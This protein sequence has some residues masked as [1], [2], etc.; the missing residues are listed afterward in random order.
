M[1]SRWIK[2]YITISIVAGDNNTNAYIRRWL[3]VSLSFSFNRQDQ[4]LLPARL[5]VSHCLSARQIT[6]DYRLK[7]LTRNDWISCNILVICDRPDAFLFA[8][9][10]SFLSCIDLWVD[11]VYVMNVLIKLFNRWRHKRQSLIRITRRRRSKAQ[12]MRVKG[13]RRRLS[14]TT[15]TFSTTS[16][17][18]VDI[19]CESSCFFACQSYSQDP[20]CFPIHL[21]AP[22]LPIGK[23]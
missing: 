12:K 19:K 5:N 9:S 11:R 23:R 6:K 20:W 13:Q 18:Q 8:L 4:L 21:R 10:A 1:N 7:T 22:F 3:S 2:W 14:P 17:P 16:G 15:M